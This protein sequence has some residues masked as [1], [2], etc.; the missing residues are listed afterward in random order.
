MYTVNR[1]SQ[2]FNRLNSNL[3]NLRQKWRIFLVQKKRANYRKQNNFYARNEKRAY[4]LV[5]LLPAE[6]ISLALIE[7]DFS[8]L[9]RFLV[10]HLSCLAAHISRSY[11]NKAP[12]LLSQCCSKS[13]TAVGMVVI[14]R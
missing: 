5:A 14:I 1:I 9:R 11:K 8:P 10:Y 13:G 12:I 7:R 6:K 3:L 4:L 2:E